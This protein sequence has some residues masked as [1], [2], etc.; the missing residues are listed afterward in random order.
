MA[1][2]RSFEP[3]VGRGGLAFA[4]I[5]AALAV[6]GWD[7]LTWY[8][9]I[10]RGGLWVGE[11]LFARQDAWVLGAY[12]LALAGFGVWVMMAR[13]KAGSAFASQRSRAAPWLVLIAAIAMVVA[14]RLGRAFVFHDY[15]PSRDEVMTELA[16]AYFAEG[17]MGWPIPAEWQPFHRAMM[18]EFYSPYGADTH[19]TAI[20]LPVHAAIVALFR[21]LGDAAL[22]APAML[23][24]GLAMLWRVSG[25]IFGAEEGHQREARIIVM[26]MALSSA[27]LLATGMTYFAMTSHFAFNLI[28]LAL[29]LKD[30][31]WS[32]ALAMPVLVLAAGLHQWHFPLLFVG[33]FILW[34]LLRRQWVA[35]AWHIVAVALVVMI[36]AKLWPMALADLVGPPPPTDVHRTPTATEKVASLFNR[37][38]SWQPLINTARLFAWNNLLLLPLLAL[39]PLAVRW[40]PFIRTLFSD[41]PVVLPLLL[42]VIA[43]LIL[44]IYQGYG[45]GFRYMHGQMGPLCLLAG[46]GW[47]AVARRIPSIARALVISGTALSLLAGFWLIRD[48]EQ[49]VRGYARSM[50][51]IRAADA[52]V[53]LVD[54]R[55]GFYFN[56]FVRFDHGVLRRPVV[57]GLHMLTM[58]QIDQL[59]AR[60]TVAIADKALFWPLG[61][62]QVRLRFSQGP[63]I[64]ARL[65]HMRDRRCGVF[66]TPEATGEAR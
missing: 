26:V 7:A 25:Q 19:W 11:Y 44:S 37:L 15:S 45:W 17:R 57:I 29:V 31:A 28:W 66:L 47:L 51:A 38:D 3:D 43:G 13:G 1:I 23:G 50:A 35:T 30:R 42:G 22:A 59:C 6:A 55:G 36:W 2:S 65:A 64:E 8:R 9:R 12:A 24:L 53:V 52:D 63:M 34:L 40:R 18:P 33:P 32:H 4:L 16:G 46:F 5:A 58:D 54:L 10:A 60:Y 27:Q 62:H 20:Y 56:D 14:A 39:A 21:W 48:T 61:V 41:P 49:Y